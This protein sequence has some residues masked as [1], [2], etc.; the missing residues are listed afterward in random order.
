MSYNGE[1]IQHIAF[2]CDNILLAWDK[3]KAA[4]LE[5]M[6]AP[7]STYYEILEERLPGHGEP[8]DQLQSHWRRY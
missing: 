2:A 7:P 1:G 5:L 4:G 8:A 6:T 3:L